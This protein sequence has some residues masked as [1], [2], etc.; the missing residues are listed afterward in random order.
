MVSLKFRSS[1]RNVGFTL[2]EILVV[3]SLM[4]LLVGMVAPAYFARL[5]TAK[6]VV[7]EQNLFTMRG[8]IDKFH[9]DRGR[10]PK[11]IVELVDSKYLNRMPIDPIT[12]SDQT[13]IEQQPGIGEIDTAGVADVKSGAEGMNR[14]GVPYAEM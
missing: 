8:A 13:W 9:A 7:L 4:M 1:M 11:K 12:S 3:L 2:I 14:L 6:E 10:F 5:Q